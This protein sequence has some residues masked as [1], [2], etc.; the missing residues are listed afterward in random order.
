M[1]ID[2]IPNNHKSEIL[3][4]HLALKCVITS[5]T[6]IQNA[7]KELVHAQGRMRDK[8][9]EGDDNVKNDLWKELHEKGDACRDVLAKYNVIP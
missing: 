6:E 1:E 4:L 2:P 5:I 8:Y 3:N 7:A 9:S